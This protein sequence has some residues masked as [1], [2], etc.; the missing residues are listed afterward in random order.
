MGPHLQ[1]AVRDLL[2]RHVTELV[3]PD[4]GKEDNQGRQQQKEE[5]LMTFYHVQLG[6]SELKRAET[7]ISKLRI[8]K[9][10]SEHPHCAVS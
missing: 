10:D 5:K 6:N 2:R 9:R 7:R 4:P 3:V 1:Q 8:E